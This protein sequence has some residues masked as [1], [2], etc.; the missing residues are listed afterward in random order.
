[1]SESVRCDRSVLHRVPKGLRPAIC[2]ALAEGWTWEVRGAS[3]ISLYPPEGHPAVRVRA[4]RTDRRS[5][6]KTLV[7]L[8]RAG[9]GDHDHY[10]PGSHPC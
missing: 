6:V 7:A 4:N 3:A 5:K 1:M 8:R 10:T 2:D 9:L